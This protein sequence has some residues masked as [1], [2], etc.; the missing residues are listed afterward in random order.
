MKKRHSLS[1]GMGTLGTASVAMIRS[2]ET[3]VI[4][5]ASIVCEIV[6]AIYYY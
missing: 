2:V 3:V 6:D 4:S 5:S 1:A